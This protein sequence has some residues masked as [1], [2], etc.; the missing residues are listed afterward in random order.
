MMASAV[1]RIGLAVGMCSMIAG[2]AFA[3]TGVDSPPPMQDPN[4]KKRVQ[5]T[6]PQPLNNGAVWYAELELPDEVMSAKGRITVNIIIG[7]STDGKA[8]TCSASSD[9]EILNARLCAAL[10]ANARF[11]PATDSYGKPIES[12]WRTRFSVEAKDDGEP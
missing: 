8:A 9:Y 7:V 11:R 4:H 5:P 2:A 1:S 10:K 6:Y 12:K 3:Q